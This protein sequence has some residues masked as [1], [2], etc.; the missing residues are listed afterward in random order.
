MDDFSKRIRKIQQELRDLKTAGVY[1]SIIAPC[2][3]TTTIPRV[4]T[5]DPRVNLRIYYKKTDTNETPATFF[6]QTSFNGYYLKPY[7]ATNQTQD[8]RVD[9]SDQ[10]TLNIYS[11]RQIYAIETSTTPAPP[12]PIIPPEPEP[13]TPAD[14]WIQYRNFNP[15]NMGTRAGYCLQNCRLGFGIMT[16]Y[17][18]SARADMNSQRANGTL[19]TDLPPP[20]NIAVP[21]YCESGTPN[22][23]VVVWD[24]GTVYSDGKIVKK[25]LSAW[26]TV[27]G[28]GELCDGRRVVVH[29]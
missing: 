24:H 3:Y 8:I 1:P 16:G 10:R 15:A 25:G 7:D 13:P 28:W 22:G 27:Y 4:M 18:P 29:S 23:H 12:E 14:E 26:A 5:G 11:T 21:V 19:H 20:A 9:Y 6:N 17:F 2:K